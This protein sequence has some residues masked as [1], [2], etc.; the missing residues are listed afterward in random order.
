MYTWNSDGVFRAMDTQ[1]VAKPRSSGFCICRM[2]VSSS[3]MMT[4][5]TIDS[6]AVSRV[7]QAPASMSGSALKAARQ[8][9]L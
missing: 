2:T 3:A 5:R 1:V 4:P 9:K 6:A 7:T 8:W